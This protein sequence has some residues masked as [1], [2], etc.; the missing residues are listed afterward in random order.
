MCY[1]DCVYYFIVSYITYYSTYNI[2]C[3]PI[4]CSAQRHGL[5]SEASI[6]EEIADPFYAHCKMHGDKL[7]SKQKKRNFLALHGHV[8]LFRENKGNRP[9]SV[10]C[11]LL[12]HTKQSGKTNF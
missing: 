12:L 6:D 3:V 2:A 4:C 5:L 11:P 10:S 9:V 8:K 7:V 1:N